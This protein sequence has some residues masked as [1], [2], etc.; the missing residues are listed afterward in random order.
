MTDQPYIALIHAEIDGELDAA[1][2]ADLARC[3]LADPQ[4]RVLREDL[5]RL[6]ALLDGMK[7]VE[8]PAELQERIF[9][10]LPQSAIKRPRL[11]SPAWRLAAVLAGVVAAGAVVFEAVRAPTPSSGDLSGTIAA[12]TATM[13]DTVSVGEE[14]VSGRVSLY[15]DRAQ[16]ALKFELVTG[17]PVDVLVASGGHTVRVNGLK[18][19]DKS[20]T[21][22]GTLV[23]LPPGFQLNGEPVDL[24]FLMG[25]RAVGKAT[26]RAS[27]GR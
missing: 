8:P 16:L 18:G 5:R 6:A 10:A 26:L 7:A 20:G 13:V 19:P 3:L 15:R 4:A 14:A 27:A 12:Q 1:Q 2:R 24:T 23:R 22:P 21:S 17:S 11:L 25:G 9:A